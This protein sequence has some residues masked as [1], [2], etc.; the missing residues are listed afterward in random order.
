MQFFKEKIIP[1]TILFIGIVGFILLFSSLFGE[2]NLLIGVSTVTAMLMFLERDLT[3]HPVLN[4]TK[5]ISLNLLIGVAAF[6]AG[7]NAFLAVPINFI[8]MFIIS[9]TLLF[10]L[11]NPLYLPFSLQYIFVLAVP[12]AIDQMPMRLT[13]LVFGALAIM[14]LQ[15]LANQ[16]KIKKSGDKK[17]ETVCTALVDKINLMKKTENLDIVNQKITTDIS[18]LRSI[19]YDKREDSYYLT[20]EA[21]VR[22][23]ISAS[24]EKINI[25][26]DSMQNDEDEHQE[27]LDQLIHFLTFAR[28]TFTDQKALKELEN[29]FDLTLKNYKTEHSRSLPV[30]RMLNN[31]DSLKESLIELNGLDK[32]NQHIVKNLELIPQKF[33]SVRITEKKSRTNSIKFSYAVRMAVAI[34]FTGFLVD[35]FEI[36][37]GRWMMFTVLS[38]IIP[39]YEQSTKKMRDRIFATLIGALLVSGLFM[40][41]Q[42]NLMRTFLLMTAGYLMNYIKVYRYSTILVTF[43]AIGAVALITDTTE[44]LTMHRILLVIAGVVIALLINK[45]ILPYKLDDANNDLKGMYRDTIHEMLMEIAAQIKGTGSN[46]AMK[47]LLIFSNMMEDRLKLNNQD[48]KSNEEITWLQHQRRAASSIYE[49]YGWLDKHGIEKSNRPVVSSRL[50]ILLNRTLPETELRKSLVTLKEQIRTMPRIEDRMVLS[51]ILEI[52]EE[53]TALKALD[54]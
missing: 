41:F 4:T 25:L 23:N 30:L 14:G 1:N 42:D 9:Y 45:L 44:I 6:L 18:G 2:S 32:E 31:I 36:T 40:I 5:L 21:R 39:I 49:L 48:S 28:D 10:N 16:K 54:S 33:K 26:L 34:S 52:T 15:L 38:V 29:A 53:I 19:I 22:L 8:V 20:E 43:S 51:V 7:F 12:V 35:F 47:N 50:A 37:E 17:L 3:S 24:L 11:K 27:I 46:H 13:S